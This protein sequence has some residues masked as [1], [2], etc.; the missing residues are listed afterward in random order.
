MIHSLNK[1]K[2]LILADDNILF[3]VSDFI[4][5]NT[6]MN[7]DMHLYFPPCALCIDPFKYHLGAFEVTPTE[8][9]HLPFVFAYL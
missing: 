6:Y 8:F 9:I 3:V 2:C 1:Y 7:T 4:D 5:V